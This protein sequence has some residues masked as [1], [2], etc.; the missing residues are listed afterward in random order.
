MSQGKEIYRFHDEYGLIQ[1]FDDG[2]KR[3]LAFGENDEQS[4]QLKSDPYQLQHDYTQAMLLV[5]LFKQPRSMVLLG[6]GGGTIAATL[7]HYLPE[8]TLC[9]VELRQQVVDVARRYFQFPRSERIDVYVEDASEFLQRDNMDKVDVLFSDLYGEE[10]LD[11]Q[12]TQSWFIE[13]CADSLNDDGWLV[14]NCWQQHRGEQE[15]LA[16]LK[17]YFQDVRVC[18]TVEGN[19]VIL[20]GKQASSLSGTQQKASVK[21]WSKTLGFSLASCF[22][23]LKQLP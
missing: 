18:L 7:H 20:A 23:R 19:W 10:G 3:Y 21:K 1:V 15:M 12:Q 11:L 16:A 8:L 14:L 2:N 13:S 22:S 17:E 4:C 5:L 6:L 9:V